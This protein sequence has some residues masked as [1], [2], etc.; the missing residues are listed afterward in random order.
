MWNQPYLETCCRAALHRLHLCG[1]TGR[2]AGLADD[3]CLARLMAMGLCLKR[4]DGRFAITPEGTARHATEI[5]RALAGES[6]RHQAA[7]AARTAVP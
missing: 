2:P 5:R 1:I 6:A 3:P 7:A 4:P